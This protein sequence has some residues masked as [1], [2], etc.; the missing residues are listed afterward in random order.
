M[1]DPARAKPY[2]VLDDLPLAGR[3]V[4]LRLDINSPIQDGK[5]AKNDRMAA[6][7]ETLDELA[8]RRAK[9]VI[10]A[11]Q[12]R[13][14]DADFTSMKAHADQ[15]A[16]ELTRAKI[17]FVPDV[18][19]SVALAEIAKLA[20]GE[21]LMIDNVR[22]L[23]DETRKVG[24]DE[25]AKA[26]F[27]RA[28]AGAADFYV[29]DGFSAAHR[30]QA[31]LVGFAE[32]IPC[33]AGPTMD[34]E[35]TALAKAVDAPEPPSVYF[36]GGAKPEDSIA[37]MRSNFTKGTLDT[38]LLGGVVA[39]LFLVAR[40][41]DIGTDSK[42]F[43]KRKGVL[44][45]LPDAE[46]LLDEFD[47]N[48]VTPEDVAI[49][50]TR[51]ERVNLWIEDLPGEGPILDI[52][53]ETIASYLA[54]IDAAGS[55]MMNGPAGLYE[56]PLFA[57]GTRAVIDAFAKADVFSLLGG[58]HTTTALAEFGYSHDDFGYVSLAGGALMAYLTGEELPA[59]EALKASA[60]KFRGKV[61]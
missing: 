14:G 45:L 37:V 25:H 38:A 53:D 42:E 26:P 28:L 32:L 27:I 10:V 40:G 54:T 57:K 24:P 3:T 30:A 55:L 60:S 23:A 43:M 22:G 58:G 44:D 8:R 17:R 41:H 29:N 34:R 52:G 12:G 36:L 9:T 49:K 15:L 47:A 39:N 2:L 7:V 56:E 5:L 31:T 16:A 50:N 13:K 19:G 20:E 35:L 46:K 1:S 51:G 48:I 61:K 33:A 18:A 6:A 4:L 21:A 11:H 59:V